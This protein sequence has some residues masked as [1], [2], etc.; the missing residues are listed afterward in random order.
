MLEARQRV[1]G[2]VHTLK[3]QGFSAGVDLGASIITGTATNAERGLR[4]DPSAIIARYTI[5]HASDTR[6]LSVFV[7]LRCQW[8]TAVSAGTATNAER[9]LRCDPSAIIAR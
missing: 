7:H 9:G 4:C 1:G 2:R 3:G 5:R 8:R 6:Y